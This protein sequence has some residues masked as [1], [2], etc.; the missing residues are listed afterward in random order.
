MVPHTQIAGGASAPKTTLGITVLAVRKGTQE[1]L[2]KGGFQLDSS[3]Q[4]A[5]PYYVDVRYDNKGTQA[6]AR[7]LDV[8]L[9]N[10][11]GDL[12]TATTIISLG[13][14]PFDKCA[15][16]SDGELAPGGSYESCS[17]FL[18]PDGSEPNKVSFL[19]NDPGKETQFVY[20]NVR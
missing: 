18:V 6:I 7:D 14:A 8:G 19:P 4:S 9:E 15:R 16:V 5:T 11:N 12:I 13:G 1:E 10:Q 2:T 20:W 3:E 17:L